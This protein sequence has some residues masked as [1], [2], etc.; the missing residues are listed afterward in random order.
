[1][2]QR[3]DAITPLEWLEVLK[4]G[5]ITG[6]TPRQLR[7][8][9]ATR[10]AM[11]HWMRLFSITH[12]RADFA[13]YGVAVGAMAIFVALPRRQAIARG[14]RRWRWA[15]LRPGRCWSRGCTVLCSTGLRLSKHGTHAHHAQPAARIGT[16]TVVSAGL[17]SGLVF[18]PAWWMLGSAPG[19]AFTLG[20]TT[21]Y[22][23]YAVTHHAVHHWRSGQGAD[24]RGLQRRK[25]WHAAHHSA[26][27]SGVRSGR[28][29]VS[30]SLWVSVFKTNK[31]AISPLVKQ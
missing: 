13:L 24:S 26:H 10:S 28:Y 14:R 20:V 27:A 23:V 15:G 4:D 2:R 8:L 30:L 9:R 11:T 16:P 29:G 22:F 18:V 3:T 5:W 31:K 12:S 19:V 25:V 21:G 7:A 1:M 17:V 6:I